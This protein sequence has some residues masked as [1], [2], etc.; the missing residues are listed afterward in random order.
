MA[1]FTLNLNFEG[2]GQVLK[3][4]RMQREMG[5][6]AR[7]IATAAGPGFEAEVI[8]GRTR[9]RAIV[10]AATHEALNAQRRSGALTRAIDAGRR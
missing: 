3:G 10:F 2:V 1:K 8:V 5:R 6:R 4:D 7:A 9:A